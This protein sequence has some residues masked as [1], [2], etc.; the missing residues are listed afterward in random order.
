MTFTLSRLFAIAFY[1]ALALVAVR[2]P[3][4]Y[5]AGFL[6]F[7]AYFALAVAAIV[8]FDRRST[9][10]AGYFLIGLLGT[11]YAGE[12]ANSAV[13]P[14]MT[15]LSVA[16]GSIEYEYVTRVLGAYVT[17]IASC[18]GY[19]I[20]VIVTVTGGDRPHSDEF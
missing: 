3:N 4:A 18:L 5:L 9:P 12:V 1:S 14:V 13:I 17:L 11:L 10:A 16:T 7:L 15:G 2:S 19:L 6:V 8:A 20:G